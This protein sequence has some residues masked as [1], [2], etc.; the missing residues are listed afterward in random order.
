MLLYLAEQ[1]TGQTTAIS[2]VDSSPSSRN[3]PALFVPSGTFPTFPC[4]EQ[5]DS[6]QL[7]TERLTAQWNGCTVNPSGKET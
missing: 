1:E 3:T 2:A 4:D 7:L 6:V 5:S